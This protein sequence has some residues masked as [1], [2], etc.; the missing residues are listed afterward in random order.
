MIPALVLGS[1]TAGAISMLAGVRLLVPHGGVFAAVIPGAVTGLPAY[2]GA[3]ATGTV[4]TAAALF[5]LKRP[6]APAEP[7][8]A[9]GRLAEA[10]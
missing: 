10:A 7:V 6:L 2:L 3:I 9:D 1:A 8:R 5:V 4:V